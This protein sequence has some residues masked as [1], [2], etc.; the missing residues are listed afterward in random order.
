M[1]EHN[2]SLSSVNNNRWDLIMSSTNRIDE[3]GFS[4]IHEVSRILK[5]E[6]YYKYLKIL[7]DVSL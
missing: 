3:D 5:L 6:K 7:V 2:I 1:V 4:N